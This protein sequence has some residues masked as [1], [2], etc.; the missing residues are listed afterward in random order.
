[1]SKHRRLTALALVLA[2][3]CVLVLPAAAADPKLTYT[4]SGS[5]ARLKLQNM[6]QESI[7]GVQ[8]ALTLVGKYDSAS[9]SPASSTAYSPRC[10]CVVGDTSTEVTVYLTDRSPLNKNGGLDMGSLTLPASFSM[11]EKAE[12]TLLDRDLKPLA[13]DPQTVSVSRQS[14]G[15][16]SGGGGSSR[17]TPTPTPTPTPSPSPSPAPALPFDDVDENDWFFNEVKYVYDKGMM[18][19]TASDAFAPGASTSRGMLV[20]IL[21]RLAGSPAAQ[22]PAFPDVSPT[23]YYASPVGWAAG[24]SIVN[25]YEDGSFRPDGLLTREQLAAILYRYSRAVGYS[26]AARGNLTGFT[27]SATISSYALEPMSWAVGAGL[28]SGMGDGTVNPQG[29]AT[30]AQVATILTR[31]CKSFVD[32]SHGI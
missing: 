26:T 22:G 11:P 28:L 12:L 3:T 6:G 14:T 16:G 10:T 20:T 5:T 18:N 4:Q 1:M 2:L 13:D 17:P 23:Q 24:Q 30:R 31:F 15:G 9:F 7:Y 32:I 19:G 25:G 8:L 29:Q 21:Y 27:D